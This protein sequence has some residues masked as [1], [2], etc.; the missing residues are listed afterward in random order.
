MSEVTS[1]DL[2]RRAAPS[3]EHRGSVRCSHSQL[4]LHWIMISV[5]LGGW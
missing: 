4:V 1:G 2:L 5:L 3:G